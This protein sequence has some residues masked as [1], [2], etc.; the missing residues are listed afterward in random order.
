MNKENA[1]YTHSGILFS[2]QKEEKPGSHDRIQMKLADMI[3]SEISLSQKDK[4]CVI[5]LT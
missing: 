3:L 4:D 1:V 5:P 2:L